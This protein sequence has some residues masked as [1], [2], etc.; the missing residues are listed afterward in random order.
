MNE[1]RSRPSV[2]LDSEK[3]T[4]AVVFR[5]GNKKLEQPK[6]VK[7]LLDAT[8]PL[9]VTPVLNAAAVIL[10]LGMCFVF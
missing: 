3:A 4:A 1:V 6:N 10:S 8:I 9:Y 5:V 2:M 7:A